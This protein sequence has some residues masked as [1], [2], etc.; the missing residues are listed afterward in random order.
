MKEK[1][2]LSVKVKPQARHRKVEA[3]S[4]SEYK[5]SVLSPPSRGK[6][7]R[8]VVETL[9]SYFDLPSSRVKIMRGEKSRQK[10]VLLEVSEK[11][12]L[13]FRDKKIQF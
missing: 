1:I 11:Q 3:I 4:P 12:V 9:A 13:K 6:A 8:E 5:V 2:Y 7:N 10:L